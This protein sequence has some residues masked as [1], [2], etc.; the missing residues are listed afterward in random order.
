MCVF[1]KRTTRWRAFLFFL[2]ALLL[3]LAFRPDPPLRLRRTLRCRQLLRTCPAKGVVF[4][5]GLI[6][7]AYDQLSFSNTVMELDRLQ[8]HLLL[9]YRMAS[10]WWGAGS[11]VG[12]YLDS[13]S[14]TPM[15][16]STRVLFQSQMREDPRLFT[17]NGSLHL[18][19]TMWGTGEPHAPVRFEATKSVFRHFPGHLV[20]QRTG[21]SPLTAAVTVGA[22][23]DVMPR[24]GQNANTSLHAPWEKN[25]GFF[26]RGEELFV[27]YSIA[28]FSVYRLNTDSPPQGVLVAHETWSLPGLK[29]NLRGGTPP[30]LV[31]GLWYVFVHSASMMPPPGAPRHLFYSVFAITF[32]DSNFT[33]HRATPKPLLAK[34]RPH[35]YFPC[36]A[37][38]SMHAHKWLI[39]VGA[40]DARIELYEISSTALHKLLH[41]VTT[42][43]DS[44][45][46]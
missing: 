24:V 40:D 7:F 6:A 45:M 18:S 29:N 46:H 39:S 15:E 8:N 22:V 44:A 26:S 14:L 16:D 5:A 3:V 30:V 36:G 25:W 42:L 31:D 34:R 43:Q 2:S 20:W 28:P 4:N 13:S 1:H 27:V 21:F 12:V 41:P 11:I 32:F 33:V 10:S 17:H 19:Y 35:V 23:V 37:I 38:Y 9:V